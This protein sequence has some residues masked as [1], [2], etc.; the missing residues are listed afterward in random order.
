[1]NCVSRS[2]N[3]ARRSYKTRL[4]LP[5]IASR[6]HSKSMQGTSRPVDPLEW[7]V[8]LEVPEAYTV[9]VPPR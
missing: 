3:C 9:A 1:M 6:L 2:V 5:K 4:R 7:K 8:K